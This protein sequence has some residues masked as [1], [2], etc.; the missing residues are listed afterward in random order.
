MDALDLAVDDVVKEQ[1]KDNGIAHC[2]K[3]EGKITK[4]ARYDASYGFYTQNHLLYYGCV[5]SLGQEVS[6]LVLTE[7]H[8]E[9]VLAFSHNSMMAGH[10]G[11]KGT[12]DRAFSKW[13]GVE[14]NIKRYMRS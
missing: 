6:Q 9:I 8:R 5:Y 11:V 12:L 2:V 10:Q 7:K 3:N 4:R 14:N 13:P 1:K